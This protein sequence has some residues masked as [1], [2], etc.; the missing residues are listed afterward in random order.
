MK[1]RITCVHHEGSQAAQA[2]SIMS[3]YG[4]LGRRVVMF[5]KLGKVLL[6]VGL[7]AGLHCKMCCADN[8]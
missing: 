4:L 5:L 8:R 6:K 7:Y 3:L 2:A 1:L